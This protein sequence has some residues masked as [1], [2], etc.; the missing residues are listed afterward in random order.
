MFF[1]FWSIQCCNVFSFWIS[2]LLKYSNQAYFMI[3]CHKTNYQVSATQRIVT[4]KRSPRLRKWTIF[5]LAWSSRWG[6]LIGVGVLA[7]SRSRDAIFWRRWFSTTDRSYDCFYFLKFQFKSNSKSMF[8]FSKH[9]FLSQRLKK[10]EFRSALRH[11]GKAGGGHFVA[12]VKEA[13]NK[14]WTFNDEAVQFHS[15]LPAQFQGNTW[16]A[17]YQRSDD[18]GPTGA[19]CSSKC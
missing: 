7:R 16:L 3:T 19:S 10:Y 17:F 18:A 4:A 13:D 5:R 14:F 11:E 2:N 15:R 9:F 12:V 1:F 6:A 8:L